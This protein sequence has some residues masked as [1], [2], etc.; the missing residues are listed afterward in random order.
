M[1]ATININANVQ[2]TFSQIINLAKQLP[3]KQKDQLVAMLMKKEEI[4]KE[5]V[6][7]KIKEGLEE[8]KLYKQGK[9]KLQPLKEFL[10][11]L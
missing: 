9:I 10:E 6:I 5:E 7:A 11:E 1:K 8:V 2:L 4:T 3:Q